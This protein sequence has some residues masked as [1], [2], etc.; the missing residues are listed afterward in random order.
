M[1]K[2]I[3]NIV[4]EGQEKRPELETGIIDINFR[5]LSKYMSFLLIKLNTF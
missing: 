3:N 5:K 2:V 4:K 1:N